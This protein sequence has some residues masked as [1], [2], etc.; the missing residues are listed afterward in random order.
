MHR[1][2]LRQTARHTWGT[3]TNRELGLDRVDWRFSPLAV[4]AAGR[5]AGSGVDEDAVGLDGR[6]VVPGQPAVGIGSDLIG[7]PVK[8]GQIIE[9]VDLHQLAG[10]DQCW[11]MTAKVFGSVISVCPP[12]AF[13]GGPRRRPK[14]PRQKPWRRIKCRSCSRPAIRIEPPRRPIG[15]RSDRELETRSSTRKLVLPQGG[16]T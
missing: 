11:C 13:P 14:M 2:Q 16:P 3:S 1:R 8:L 15:I 9:G 5:R 7:V 12:G 4:G 6:L 10:V